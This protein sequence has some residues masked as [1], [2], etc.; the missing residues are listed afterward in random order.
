VLAC[1]GAAFAQDVVI[2]GN[3]GGFLVKSEEARDRSDV[4]R[5][6]LTFLDFMLEDFNGATAGGDFAISLGSF[7]EVGAGVNYYARTVPTVYSRFVD[8]DGTEIESDLKLRNIPIALT[9]KVFPL[10]R[11]AGVQPY[12]GGGVQFNLWQYTEVGEFRDFSN[13]DI[14]RDSFT[15]DGMEIGPVFLAG[16]RFPVGASALIGG[17]WRYSTARADLDP[18]LGFSGD[19][20]DLGGNSFLFTVSFKLR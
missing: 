19:T 1:S 10:S 13:G 11:D 17:E 5:Q 7:L 2:G 20:I 8:S 15:D 14:F 4:L 6:N 12:V 9:A 18:S 16:V 3:I